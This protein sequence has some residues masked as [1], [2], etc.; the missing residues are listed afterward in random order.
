MKKLFL[1]AGISVFIFATAQTP[2]LNLVQVVGT[3]LNSPV[4]LQNCGDERL[5]VVEQ[6]GK[7]RVVSKS[8]VV[9]T[10]PFLDIST[11]V[12]SAGNEQGLLGLAFSPNYKQNG[13]FYVNYIY[14]D[15]TSA[16]TTRISRFSVLPND[17]MQA[18]PNSEKIILSFPQPYTNHN[19]GALFFGLD[20]YLYDSQGDGGSQ[21]DPSG[22]GQNVNAYLAKL[23]RIDVS[24]PDTTYT[25]PA[26]NPFANQP[27]AKGEV[28]AYGLRNPWRCN[29]D[30]ITGDIWIA[31]VGQNTY[32]EVDMMPFGTSGNNFGWKCREAAHDYITS[33]CASSGFTDPIMEY[34]HSF[35]LGGHCSITGGYVYRG[36]QYAN[37]WSRYLCTDYCSGQFFSIKQ[38]GSNTFDT[39][40]LNNLTNNQYTGFGLD[41]TGEMYVLYRGT[42]TGGRVYRITETTNC[43]PVAFITL[44]DTITG[45]S[46][47]TVTALRGDTLNYQWYNSAGIINGAANYQFTA[48]QSGWYKV[49]VSK[50]NNA[51][52]SMSDSVYVQ[53]SDTS[54]LT[55]SNN[56]LS[57]CQ[58]SAPVDLSA[59][60]LPN[61]GSY[62]GTGVANNYFTPS[63]VS[64]SSQI[65]YAYT[66]QYGCT[67]A[68]GFSLQVNDTT[69]LIKNT[70][71]SVFCIT[72]NAV[73]L[74][75]YFNYSGQYSGTG[76]SGNT[77]T[78]SSAGIGLYPVQI[79]Y[80]NANNCV[81]T[82][83]FTLQVADT[84]AL[85][86]TISDTIFCRDAGLIDLTNYT[87]PA[88][89]IFSGNNVTGASFDPANALLGNN[90]VNYQ[91]TNNNGCIS[92]AGFNVNITECTGV[93]A[94]NNTIKL[95]LYPNPNNGNFMLQITATQSQTAAITITDATGRLCY[96]QPLQIQNGNQTIPV[97]ASLPKGTYNMLLKGSDLNLTKLITVY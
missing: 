19:G 78:P 53:V 15:G 93:Q 14:K 36:T 35:Q 71:D 30:R 59:Y 68:L 1:L 10:T 21:D 44:Q 67:S 26:S 3:G 83:G 13:Y 91:Y 51:C 7:I 2:N 60:I 58:N 46:P 43:N 86:I 81:S 92:V 18:D 33:G 11:R 54:A 4:D 82:A 8:G 6:P 94:L 29:I 38:T 96:K 62:S 95:S 12:Q 88:G 89:G 17:S 97:T 47:V 64:G 74:S 73:Q 48:T 42:G 20:G 87:S 45:C 28:W 70:Q 32:E 16:G 41:N 80:T 61:G 25:I 40:V 63:S 27:N 90:P 34:S 76:V 66:N 75:G 9:T 57:F 56:P 65:A 31:D 39:L 24:N 77:F 52:Q 5:F 84:T 79:T 69:Q 22:N 85:N 23:L 49:Q 55:T 37:L 50:T 72:D